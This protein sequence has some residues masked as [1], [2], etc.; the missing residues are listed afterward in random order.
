MVTG[1]Y[2]RLQ[3]DCVA[4][5]GLDPRLAGEEADADPIERLVATSRHA[6]YP[7]RPLRPQLSPIAPSR[8]DSRRKPHDI[9]P[10]NVPCA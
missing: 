5:I 3:T 9:S 4:N 10:K 6:V 8:K 7:A 1:Q 2:T